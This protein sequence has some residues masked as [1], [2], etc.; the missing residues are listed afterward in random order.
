VQT[1][2]GVARDELDGVEQRMLASII[3]WIR[4]PVEHVLNFAS[5]FISTNGS[6]DPRRCAAFGAPNWTTQ[7]S[8]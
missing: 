8:A 1:D 7:V 6:E 2:P 3:V 5:S 4:A